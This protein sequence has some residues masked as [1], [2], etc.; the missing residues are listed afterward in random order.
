MGVC[1]EPWVSAQISSFTRPHPSRILRDFIFLYRFEKPIWGIFPTMSM[2]I[3][4]FTKSKHS[5]CFRLKQS[6]IVFKQGQ[7]Q[8][9]W[10][11]FSLG[12]CSLKGYLWYLLNMIP[13]A[14]CFLFGPVYLFCMLCG[15]SGGVCYTFFFHF[16]SLEFY[17]QYAQRNCKSAPFMFSEALRNLKHMR[18]H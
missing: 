10:G 14:F 9:S 17:R 15:M 4:K 8:C 18:G 2:E 13:K 3:T 1:E 5:P 11:C 7:S 16:L 6:S 12:P